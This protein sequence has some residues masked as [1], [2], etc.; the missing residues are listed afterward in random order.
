MPH[1]R[2][3]FSKVFIFSDLSTTKI[4]TLPVDKGG[5][6][7]GPVAIQYTIEPAE[8]KAGGAYV[9]IYKGDLLVNLIPGNAQGQDQVTLSRGY[10]FDKNQAYF[11]QVVL[12]PGTGSEIKSDKIKIEFVNL[13]IEEKDP[14][15]PMSKLNPFDY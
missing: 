2:I 11:A 5:Y 14:E 1:L 10:Q 4:S 15:F 6:A 9:Y 3:Y 8:Y 12:N 7:I 13:Y